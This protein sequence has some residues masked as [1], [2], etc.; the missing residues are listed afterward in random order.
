MTTTVAEARP[1]YEDLA[2]HTSTAGAFMFANGSEAVPYDLA[3]RQIE[4]EADCTAEG[5]EHRTGSRRSG[6][7]IELNVG[8]RR[9]AIFEKRRGAFFHAVCVTA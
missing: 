4:I 1:L 2:T 5:P 8:P 9:E 6:S 3:G 7:G